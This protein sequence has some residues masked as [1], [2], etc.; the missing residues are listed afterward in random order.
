MLNTFDK[1]VHE[2]I[3][4]NAHFRGVAATS[5]RAAGKK[6]CI[7][8]KGFRADINVLDDGCRPHFSDVS[9]WPREHHS[10]ALRERTTGLLPRRSNAV[11]GQS[12]RARVV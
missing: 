1:K 9:Q 3:V 10:V 5:R 11:E 2:N 6:S 4:K 7:G 12:C 8:L